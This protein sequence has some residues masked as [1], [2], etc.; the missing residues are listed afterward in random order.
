MLL[1]GHHPQYRECGGQHETVLALSEPRPPSL[2]LHCVAPSGSLGQESPEKKKNK[3]HTI[4]LLVTC[5]SWQ[6]RSSC[7]WDCIHCGLGKQ[8][9]TGPPSQLTLGCYL[10]QHTAIAYGQRNTGCLRIHL[11]SC[12]GLWEGE[13]DGG[14]DRNSRPM[15]DLIFRE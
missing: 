14:S 12:R 4:D 5:R 3:Y 7:S 6:P 1:S 10:D 11:N 9:R 15:N 8:S 13:W 2:S